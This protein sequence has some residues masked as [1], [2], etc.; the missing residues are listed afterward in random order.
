MA[1]VKEVGT[2]IGALVFETALSYAD[3]ASDLSI[4]VLLIGARGRVR[5]G[6]AICVFAYLPAL[7]NAIMMKF[8]V[9]ASNM[10]G[11]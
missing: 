8:G 3:V 1:R 2:S 5:E 7:A 11:R 10:Y 9:E 4:A 6:V